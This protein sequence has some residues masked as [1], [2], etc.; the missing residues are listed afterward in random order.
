[1]SAIA[2]LRQLLEDGL[3]LESALR[4]AAIFEVHSNAGA[5]AALEQRRA[6][7]RERQARRRDL[8]PEDWQE[9][10]ARV[11]ERDAY[12]CAYCETPTDDPHCDHIIP[13]SRG[14]S[15]DLEN[16]TTSCRECNVSKG[17]RTPEEWR[18]SR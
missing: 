6:K 1:M 4:A 2:F 18:A 11:F 17:A 12:T 7:D 9:L 15:N 3:D 16:L 14:G 5:Q 8:M 13:I 10:R